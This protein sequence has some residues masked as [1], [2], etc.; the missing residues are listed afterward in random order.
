MVDNQVYTVMNNNDQVPFDN[1]HYL[2]LNIAMGGN[3]GGNVS[4]GYSSDIMELDYVRV[5][6][7]K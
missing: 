4:P 7:K 5:F 2:L 1:S 3:L 6:Q